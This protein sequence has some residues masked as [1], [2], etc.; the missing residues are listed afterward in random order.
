M[1]NGFYNCLSKKFTIFREQMNFEKYLI[2]RCIREPIPMDSGELTPDKPTKKSGGWNKTF[3]MNEEGTVNETGTSDPS[4]RRG[5]Q[6]VY[7]CLY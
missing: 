2:N 6:Q 1:I 4:G 3:G 5:R 7:P